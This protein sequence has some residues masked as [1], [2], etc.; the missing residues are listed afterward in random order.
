MDCFCILM[1]TF[2]YGSRLGDF[3]FSSVALF[4]P[5]FHYPLSKISSPNI[6][7]EDKKQ[8]TSHVCSWP[9]LSFSPARIVTKFEMVNCLCLK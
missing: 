8:F 6:S 9:T 2:D 1:V 3:V 4:S 5:P 7:G